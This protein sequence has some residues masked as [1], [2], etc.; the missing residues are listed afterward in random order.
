SPVGNP[1]TP[2]PPPSASQPQ[3]T[4][5]EWTAPFSWPIV[6]LHLHLLPD[7]RVLSWGY[8]GTPQIWNPNTGTFQSAPSPSLVFCAGHD[9]LGD[10][11]LF[12]VGGHVTHD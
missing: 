9:F 8:N 12:V 7:G 2:C 10:G 1:A 5:G 4:S 6:A 11:R 3:A